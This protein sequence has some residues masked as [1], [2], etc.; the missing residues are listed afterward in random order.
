M[1][2]YLIVFIS[3][4]HLILYNTDTSYS[5]FRITFFTINSV[6][7]W[8]GMLVDNVGGCVGYQ[9]QQHTKRGGKHASWSTKHC[10]LHLACCWC[11]TF[12][13]TTWMM[14]LQLPSLMHSNTTVRSGLSIYREVFGREEEEVSCKYVCGWGG[15]SSWSAHFS[16][17]MQVEVAA[18]LLQPGDSLMSFTLL[19]HVFIEIHGLAILLRNHFAIIFMS[20]G[21]RYP[22][23]RARDNI[24]WLG[25]SVS[26]GLHIKWS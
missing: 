13:R 14:R 2:E 9:I 20:T 5:H 6:S 10:V 15:L 23:E 8:S 25:M 17:R 19:H 16:G 1:R 3:I 24:A 11:W 4:C 12:L 21:D 7:L 26:V 22:G 18:T